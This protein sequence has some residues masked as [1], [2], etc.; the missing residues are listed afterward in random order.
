MSE[1]KELIVNC[2]VCDVRKMN[3]ESLS[4]YE[5]VVINADVILVDERS[6]SI[7]NKFPMVC[8]ADEMVDAEGDVAI[9]SIN[10]SYEIN[11]DTLFKGKTVICVNGNL[12]VSAGT[13]K[14]LENVL[15]ICVNGCARYPKSMAP[16]MDRMT[17]NGKARCIPDDCIDLKPVFAIDKYFPIRAKQ[18]GKYYVDHK[19]VLTDTDVDV[20]ALAAKKIQFVTE[21]F[22]VREEYVSK[23]IG[24]FEE[25]VEMDVIPTGFAYIGE[26]AELNESLVQRYGKCL[27]IDGD[28]ILKDGSERC[29][30]KVEKIM[31]NGDVRLLKR[32]E[33]EF[34]RVDATYKKQV[35]VK[36][37]YVQNQ[38]CMV[39]DAALLSSLPD[40]LEIGNCAVLRVEKDVKPELILERLAIGNCSQISCSP[41]Q[42]SA[43]QLVCGNVAGISDGEDENDE[44]GGSMIERLKKTV[45]SKVIN[46]DTY[47]L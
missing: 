44:E 9:I 35:Y 42:K 40:G 31:V 34:V 3:E 13:E 1:K 39:V 33:K 29:F 24:M 7:F 22:L 14:V 4:D 47:I 6:R 5:R 23:T 12:S 16:F 10:G 43:L 18:D 32:L 21:R 2:D 17:V 28:L 41:E 46:V 26:D 38:A 15:K 30:D 45:N 36:G 20:E 11:G 8:N 37:R 25:N 27:Y 19:V